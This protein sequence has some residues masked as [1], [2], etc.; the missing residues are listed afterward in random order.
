MQ[1]SGFL[2]VR[3][4]GLGDFECRILDFGFI[5]IQKVK[6]RKNQVG[7]EGESGQG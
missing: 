3:E 5:K 1:D 2:I 7:D 4:K 6:E